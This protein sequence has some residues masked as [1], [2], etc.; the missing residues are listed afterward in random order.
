MEIKF[1]LGLD[2]KFQIQASTLI[3]VLFAF[4]V[5]HIYRSIRIH[6]RSPVAYW[7]LYYCGNPS[8]LSDFLRKTECKIH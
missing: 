8:R 5:G 1:R 3:I 7:R 6:Y 4:S 2:I